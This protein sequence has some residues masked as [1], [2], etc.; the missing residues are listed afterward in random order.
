MTPAECL[1]DIASR[2]E[3]GSRD[4]SELHRISG[5]IEGRE[6]GLSLQ[7][8][9]A[10][11]VETGRTRSDRPNVAHERRTEARGTVDGVCAAAWAA[12]YETGHRDGIADARGDARKFTRNPW[13]GELA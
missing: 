6:E 4:W 12:G 5:Y 2:L 3:P 11:V 10:A 8:R 13:N 7:A 1:R 9:F